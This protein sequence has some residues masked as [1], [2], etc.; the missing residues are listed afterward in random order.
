[1]FED[2]S[3]ESRPGADIITRWDALFGL[4]PE[5]KAEPK[6]KALLRLDKNPSINN[7]TNIRL[8]TPTLPPD[9]E[10]RLLLAAQTG[11]ARA[12]DRLV[13]AHLPWVQTKALEKWARLHPP[14]N[15]NDD[16]GV[17]LED[18]VAAGLKALSQ[19][20]PGWRPGRT[21]NTYYRKAVLGAIAEVAVD[22][23]HRGV[24][25]ETRIQRLIRAHPD[26]RA[27]WFREEFLRRY[28]DAS[29][30]SV[31][32]IEQEQA[33]AYAVWE[34]V[35]YDE[36]S[37]FDDAG[38]H[39]KDGAYKGGDETQF[40]GPV[41]GYEGGAVGEWSRAQASN[42]LHPARKIE[43]PALWVRTKKKSGSTWPDHMIAG[44]DRRVLAEIDKIGRRA[45]AQQLVDLSW[46]K[47]KR[48]I[49]QK[50]PRL[51]IAPSF[52]VD[53]PIRQVVQ[54]HFPPLPGPAQPSGVASYYNLASPSKLLY[55]SLNL[56]PFKNL[57]SNEAAFFTPPAYQTVP[58]QDTSCQKKRIG[59]SAPRRTSNIMSSKSPKLKAAA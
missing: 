12:T 13:R 15:S 4:D 17:T 51:E 19:S 7:L 54:T 55:R 26:W 10:A 48:I 5:D 57:P 8:R 28:P 36:A 29:I 14:G 24:K 52:R 6:T 3:G 27:E 37:S 22:W 34:P 38:D 25:A 30:P 47:A 46:K 56:E 32:E 41:R 49:E 43:H 2:F 9:E 20:I 44:R 39:D 35:K 40:T 23:R 50:Q 58:I 16:R 42:S 21:F 33:I 53:T 45:Y 11:D 1:M 59:E 18:F 31:E